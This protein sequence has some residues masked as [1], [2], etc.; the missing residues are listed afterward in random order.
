MEMRLL[1]K[2]PRLSLKQRRKSWRMKRNDLL[3]KSNVMRQNR[4]EFENL[5]EMKKPNLSE[6][7]AQKVKLIE[8]NLKK[9]TKTPVKHCSTIL[10]TSD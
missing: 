1:M 5:C 8:A 10:F 3:S 9:E 4:K 2:K 7:S 6:I